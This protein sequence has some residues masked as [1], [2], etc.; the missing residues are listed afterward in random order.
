M[1]YG[2]MMFMKFMS[3]EFIGQRYLVQFLFFT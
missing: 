3:V 2:D 1:M